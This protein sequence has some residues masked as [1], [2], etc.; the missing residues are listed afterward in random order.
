MTI[1][2]V[3][4]RCKDKDISFNMS[5]IERALRDIAGKVDLLCFGETFLQGFNSLCWDYELDK[6]VAL[7]KESDDIKQ[8]QRWTEQYKVAIL[9]GYVEKEADAL[10]SSCITIS[11]G[12]IINNYRRISK[13]WKEYTKTDEHYQEGTSVDS[14]CLRGEEITIALCGDLWD[15][16]ERFKTDSL[17]IWPVYVTFTTDDWKQVE[18]DEYAKQSFLAAKDVLMINPIDI[19]GQNHGGSSYFHDGKLVERTSYDKEQI[20]IVNYGENK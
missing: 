19:E 1:G 15:Y 10:Y 16:P 4:Y 3:S 13:G 9:T 14:F 5:Q 20:I 17:L 7:E 11:E 18:S 6:D 12:K 2:L 8:L